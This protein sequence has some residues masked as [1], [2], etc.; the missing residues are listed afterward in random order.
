MTTRRFL[1]PLLACFLVAA[2]GGGP[3]ARQAPDQ[4]RAIGVNGL[5][6][7]ASLD[8]LSFLP[9]LEVDSGSGVIISDWYVNPDARDE[10]LKVSVFVLDEDLR[11][12]AVNVRVLR[13]T[14]DGT[15]WVNAPVRAQTAL[16]IE[17]AI[18][19][20]ARQIRIQSLDG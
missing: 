16:E 8:T 9:L 12:D 3:T 14:R 5:L 4:T 17:D 20:R 15:Q 19:T 10:R 1:A 11:A 6:W 2:C 7:R 13:Q 18:L